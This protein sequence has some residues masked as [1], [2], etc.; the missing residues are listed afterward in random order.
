MVK[1]QIPIYEIISGAANWNW[2]YFFNITWFATDFFGFLII[3]PPTRKLIFKI[4]SKKY[5][6]KNK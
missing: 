3:F 4:F 1:N 5:K 2:S 6:K